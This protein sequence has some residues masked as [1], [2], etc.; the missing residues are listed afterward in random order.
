[1]LDGNSNTVND[2]TK[3]ANPSVEQCFDALCWLL[4][5]QTGK[6]NHSA[7][8]PLLQG[9]ASVLY[10]GSYPAFVEWVESASWGVLPMKGSFPYKGYAFACPS[11]HFLTPSAKK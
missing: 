4:P 5:S 8:A 2:M 3:A 6:V 11:T 9:S 7:I 1:M 10:V